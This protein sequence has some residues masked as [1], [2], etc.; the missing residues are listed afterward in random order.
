MMYKKVKKKLIS[1]FCGELAA[2]ILFALLWFFYLP[3]SGWFEHYVKTI[4]SLFAFILLEFILLQG[5]FYWYLK[6]KQV[7]NK[8][9]SNLPIS[10]LRLFSLFKKLNV[11][12][13]LI[14]III[15]V[16]QMVVSA[17]EVYWYTFVFGFAVLEQVNYYHIRL[18]YQTSEELKDLMHR[19]K[20][21]RSKLAKELY[22][23]KSKR[24]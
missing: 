9:F 4:P 10:Y 20:L 14:G 22:S 16:N 24:N 3:Q 17:K 1:L 23:L 15:L 5:S 8:D 7:S 11:L 13:I 6:W 2:T 12:L 21:T 18:S 19:K